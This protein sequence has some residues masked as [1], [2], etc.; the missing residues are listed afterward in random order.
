MIHDKTWEG[1]L[2]VK[3]FL[4]YTHESLFLGVLY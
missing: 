4:H 1:E 3:V 2:L